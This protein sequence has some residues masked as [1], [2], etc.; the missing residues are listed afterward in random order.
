[1]AIQKLFTNPQTGESGDYVRIDSLRDQRLVPEVT[2]FVGVY[3]GAEYAKPVLTKT[4]VFNN[5]PTHEDENGEPVIGRPYFLEA[6]DVDPA[7]MNHVKCGYEALKLLPEYEG[8]E[9]I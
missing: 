5:E 8:F 9:N 7:G 6:Q 3:K 4:H 1:M 2:L